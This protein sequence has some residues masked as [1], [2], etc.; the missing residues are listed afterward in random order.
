MDAKEVVRAFWRAMSTNDFHAASD[1]L[2]EDFEGVWPQSKEKIV[3]RDNFA[4]LNSAYPQ[5][6]DW[7]FKVNRLVGDACEVV[8]EVSIT[9]GVQTALAITF[10]TV[11][12]NKIRRQVEYW[13]D[14]YAAPAWR[15]QWVSVL[16]E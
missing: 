2:S 12:K 15:A 16:S 11:A 9:D 7:T 4:A 8:T 13:P 1:W 3:G 5:H 10:H 6:G 14:D